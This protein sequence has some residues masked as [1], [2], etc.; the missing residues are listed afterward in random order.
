MPVGNIILPNPVC[1]TSAIGAN[2]ELGA[3]AV[4]CY[5][6]IVSRKVHHINNLHLIDIID[7]GTIEGNY[8]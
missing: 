3:L 5:L 2:L 1:L 8:S 7:P 4:F 6:I